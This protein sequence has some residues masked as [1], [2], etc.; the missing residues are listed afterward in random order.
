MSELVVTRRARKRLMLTVATCSSVI[1]A[2]VIGAQLVANLIYD[3]ARTEFAA[4]SR[5]L[6]NEQHSLNETRSAT[7]EAVESTDSIL[8]AATSILIA[9]ESRQQLSTQLVQAQTALATADEAAGES[10][11]RTNP[12]P[13]WPWELYLASQGLA[14]DS[15][16]ARL[17]AKAV[18]VSEEDLSSKNT[19][20]REYVLVVLDAALDA[21]PSIE[22]QNVWAR[23]ADVIALRAASNALTASSSSLTIDTAQQFVALEAAVAAVQASAQDE[24]AQKAGWLY[25]SR[26]EVEAYA[27]SIAGGVLLDFDWSHLVNG[28]GEGGSAGGTATWNAASGGFATITLSDSVAEM[29]PSDVSRALVTHEVGHAI[30]SKCWEMFDWENTAANEEWATA[31]ALS[32][33]EVAD[34]NGVSLYGY[35]PQS[36]IDTASTCR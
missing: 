23:T 7:R 9:D 15:A 19:A 28:Y 30:S 5:T 8:A 26:L 29:W 22:Q 13:L 21:V 18:A 33:G 17:L 1:I 14:T 36:L 24:L 4:R 6:L 16:H 2:L 12:K 35:P 11:A 31:W 25:D 3:D 27:R 10:P 34:G 32:R 20:L